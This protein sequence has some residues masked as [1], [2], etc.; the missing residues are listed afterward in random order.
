MFSR[1]NHGIIHHPV[2]TVLVWVLLT[3]TGT[4][5]AVAGIT[6][7]TLFDRVSSDAPLANQSESQQADDIIADGSESAQQITLLVQGLKLEDPTTTA[8]VSASLAKVRNDLAK[9]DGVA[10]N[11]ADWPMVLDPLNPAFCT[12]PEVDPSTP[13]AVQCAIASPSAQ[14]MLARKGDGFF[15]TVEIAKGLDSEKESQA[16]EK[17]IERLQQAGDTLEKQFKG[18]SCQVG[19]AKLIMDD[20]TEAMKNDLAKAEL[21]ALPVALVVMVLVFAG[22][23][24]AAMPIVGA[25]ASIATCMGVVF[26]F[27]HLLTMHTSVI[28]VIS[29]IGLGLSIDYG[30]LV[31]SR[32][33][34]EL[35]RLQTVNP[36]NKAALRKIVRRAVYTA[37]VTAGRTVF[38][39]ALTIAVCIA[40]LMAFELDLMHVYGLSG[41][42]VVLFALATATTLVPALL[43]ILGHHLARP[44]LLARL[45]GISFLYSKASDVSPEVGVFSALAARVQK[46]PWWVIAGVLAL[47]TVLALPLRSIELRNSMVELLPKSSPQ[48]QFMNDFERNYPQ[49]AAT[50][51][52]ISVVSTGNAEVTRHFAED[53][54]ADIKGTKLVTGLDGSVVQEKTGYQLVTLEVTGPDPEGKAAREAVRTIRLHAPKDYNVY[55]TGPAARILDYLDRLEQGA[56]KAALIICLAVFLLLFMFTG[57]LLIPLKALITNAL[58]LLACLGVVTWIFQYGHFEGLLGFQAMPGIESYIV[59]LLLIFGF[60]LAMDY[61]V[62]LISRIKES[63][64]VNPDPAGSV[65]QGLQHSGR[66]ITS[67]ALIIVVVFLGFTTGELVLIKEIGL[68]LAIAVILDTTLVRMLLVPATMTILGR[69]NWWAPAPLARLHAKLFANPLRH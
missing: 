6:G 23:L 44:S 33:R 46:R 18:L 17:V 52:G 28:N 35:R 47:L 3:A 9:I 45:P 60:G 13:E 61:E 59:V 65:R 51:D 40:G 64:D 55:V 24:A 11:A 37:G 34:E 7:E 15:M 26:G 43:V 63:W 1:L 57:S 58:S 68:G 62:F 4:G 8:K 54:L 50:S 29:L 66:I 5:L 32:F 27:T 56:P 42:T 2:V 38:Y 16:T 36:R 31:V 12:N 69:W 21:I 48:L 49:A 53:Y 19:A 67:A 30:L 10:Y 25:L 14:G 41:L 22:F 20:I 39:S